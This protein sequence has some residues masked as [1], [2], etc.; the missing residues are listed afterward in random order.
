MSE[1][2]R[3]TPQGD[4]VETFQNLASLNEES[5]RLAALADLAILDSDAER[6]F[7]AVTK[8]AATLLGA[9]SAAVSLIDHDRQWF[10]ARHNVDFSETTRDVAFCDQVVER[11]E[12]LVVLDAS[13]DETFRDNP[14]VTGKPHIRFY[15]GAPLYLK[16]G[17]CVGSLCVLDGQPRESFDDEQLRMLQELASIVEELIEA[18]KARS[19]AS[20]A[21]EVVASTPDAVIATNRAGNIVYWNNAAQRVFGWSSEEALGKFIED[22]IPSSRPGRNE[23]LLNAIGTSRKVELIGKFFELEGR[24]KNGESFPIELSL[25]PWGDAAEGG[26]ASVVRDI[27]DRKTLEADRDNSK[28]FLDAVVSNLPSMLFVKDTESHRYL[29][30]NRKAEDIIGRSAESM[31]G[32]D[33]HQLFPTRGAAFKRND[34]LAIASGRPEQAESVFERDDGTLVNIRTT[35][36]LVDGPDR[37]HQYLLGLSED[38]TEIRQA[39]EERWKLARFDTLT[40]LLNRTSFLEHI[41][42]L[43]EDEASFAVLDINLDRF[44][45]VNDQFGHVIGD[46]VLKI[47]GGRIGTLADDDNQVARVGGDEFVCLVTGD[48]LRERTLRFVAQLTEIVREPIMVEGIT[49]H[50]GAAIGVVFHPEDGADVETLRQHADVAMHRSKSDGRGEPCFFD[51]QL[52]VAERDRRRLETNLRSAVAEGS[53]KVVFQPIVEVSSGE[54]T[55][56]EALARWTD[57]NLG[58]VAPDVFIALAEN[59]GL[60]DTLGEQILRRACEEARNW[61]E[62]MHVAVNLSPRQFASGTLVET[63]LGVL[64]D[65]GLAPGR[66]HLEVTEN[67][68]IHNAEEAFAQLTQLKQTGIKIAIDDFGVGYSSLGYFQ[69]FHFDKVKIDKSFIADMEDAIAA[70]A[71]V[72]AVVG[73]AEKLSMEVVAEGVETI[74]QQDLLRQLGASHLQGYLYSTPLPGD[75]LAR[76]FTQHEAD[77]AE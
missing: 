9:A 73:L 36:V 29:L 32:K 75:E 33:D 62:H 46:E 71:I 37:P 10:K 13:Q 55:S 17:H 2:L 70:K 16:S 30:V 22:V 45:S 6:E 54:V 28:K 57:P 20:I 12:A 15:A 72:T 14:L 38:V 74:A 53:I 4:S 41:E 44:K 43:I 77:A 50:I 3:L 31:I 7:D 76:Y 49:A 63:I 66:L 67:L 21:A 52:D 34:T 23:V 48:N 58:P 40:G 24:G 26:L 69:T 35:R 68:V 18:R 5:V 64:D 56:F 61:P 27:S 42:T 8:G 51:D 39:E 65:T 60:I 47:L 25:A 59:C 19:A 1:N 11:R